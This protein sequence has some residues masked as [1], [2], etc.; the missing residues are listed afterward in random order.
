[1]TLEDAMSQL[2]SQIELNTLLHS[3]SRSSSP[4]LMYRIHPDA[5]KLDEVVASSTNLKETEST[6]W[7]LS[8][9]TRLG[10]VI[11]QLQSVQELSSG[12]QCTAETS[13]T[14]THSQQ[15]GCGALSSDERGC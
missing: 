7:S 1:L 10:C 4:Y 15:V 11:T 2:N 3:L 6:K 8:G 13:T 14:L 5:D 12:R 9:A